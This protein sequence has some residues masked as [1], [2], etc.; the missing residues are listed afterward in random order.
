[1]LNDARFQQLFPDVKP[2]V[3]GVWP[4]QA[5]IERIDQIAEKHGIHNWDNH[6]RGR[7]EVV[8]QGSAKQTI[9]MMGGAFAGT[10]TVVAFFVITTVISLQVRERS[11][12]ISLVRMI[13]ATPKQARGIQLSEVRMVGLAAGIFGAIVGPIAGSALVALMRTTGLAP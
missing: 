1:Y 12:E 5:G 2:I 9:V 3:V 4:G 6:D 11:R 8:S 7:L 13:G 10:A